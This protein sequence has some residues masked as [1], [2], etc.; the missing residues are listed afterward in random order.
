MNQFQ[1]IIIW[2]EKEQGR[3][4]DDAKEKAV[5]VDKR[6]RVSGDHNG[7]TRQATFD[8]V[9]DPEASPG[10]VMLPAVQVNFSALSNRTYIRVLGM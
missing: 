2:A 8:C 3:G 5:F 4:W 10:Q 6:F 7:L 1:K 9:E